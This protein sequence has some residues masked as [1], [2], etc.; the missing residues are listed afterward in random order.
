MLT[1][2]ELAD[3][4]AEYLRAFFPDADAIQLE[5]IEV[6]DDNSYWFITL[7]YENTDGVINSKIWINTRSRKYKIFKIDATSGEVRSM[8]IR[9][10]A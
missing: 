5:E 4:A 8:K 6:T 3:K 10:M 2:K 1:I 7:S 9:D